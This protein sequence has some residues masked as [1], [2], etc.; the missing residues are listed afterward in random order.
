MPQLREGVLSNNFKETTLKSLW[1]TGSII[2]CAALLSLAG[3]AACQKTETPA[4]GEAASGAAA[5]APTAASGSVASTPANKPPFGFLHAPEEGA[6]VRP[7]SWAYGWALDDSGIA[8]ITVTTDTGTTSPVALGQ[9]FPGVAQ[10]YPGYPDADKAGFG[11][12][13]P[14]LDSGIHTIVVTLV[15]K[16]GGKTE[17]RRQV[18]VL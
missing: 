5:A 3:L 18:R 2:G 17:I 12:P 15:A 8:Q 4:A 10:N 7:G 16:D 13:V 9:A 14:K 1:K 6:T 11:F